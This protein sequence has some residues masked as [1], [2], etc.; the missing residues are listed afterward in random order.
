MASSCSYG[1][2]I[3]F[4]RVFSHF[5]HIFL[6]VRVLCC[7]FSSFHSLHYWI[8]IVALSKEIVSKFDLCREFSLNS[9]QE[10]RYAGAACHHRL[11]QNCSFVEFI[12]YLIYYTLTCLMFVSFFAC[13]FVSP[14]PRVEMLSAV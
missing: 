7:C 14:Q 5:F 4:L 2:E 10:L 8:I 11:F 1:V 9:L 12:Q 3:S 6:N 13:N